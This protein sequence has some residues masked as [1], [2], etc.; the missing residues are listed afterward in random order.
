MKRSLAGFLVLWCGLF[1]VIRT[2]VVVGQPS[3][4]QKLALQSL[5]T[6]C[7]GPNW[8]WRPVSA[9]IR[10]NFTDI[11]QQNP[12]DRSLPWQGITCSNDETEINEIVLSSYN[13]RGMLPAELLGLKSVNFKRS[14]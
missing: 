7:N 10:W 9:G 6:A 8:T 3:L 11:N 4:S 2:V 5:Y 13:L 1:T 12:C 14:E